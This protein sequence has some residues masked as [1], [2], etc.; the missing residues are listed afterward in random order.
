MRKSVILLFVILASAAFAQVKENLPHPYV[1]GGLALYPGGYQPAGWE[2]G[3]GLM[4]DRPHFVFDTF[5]GY[6]NGRKVDDGSEAIDQKGHDRMLRGFA[7]YKFTKSSTYV[8]A[9]A[10]WDELDTTNYIKLGWHPEVGIGHDFWPDDE[11]YPNFARMQLSWM[12]KEQRESVR[13]PDGRSCYP[14]QRGGSCGN[15]S[16]GPDFTLW[17]PSPADNKHKHVFM[18]MNVVPFMYHNNPA[19]KH[20]HW[21]TSAE[22]LVGYRF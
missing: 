4:W 5:A 19:D 3:A 20:L 10:R 14:S 18:R 9:G 11:W 7:A 21:S 17:I 6:D 12:F 8:G 1:I 13:F 22:M 16:R 2:A 15:G